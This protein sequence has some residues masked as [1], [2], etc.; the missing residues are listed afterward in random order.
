MLKIFKSQYAYSKAYIS[1]NI[2]F[3][4]Q[5]K[6]RLAVWNILFFSM[7]YWSFFVAQPA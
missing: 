6:E 1:A 7:Q 5:D 2:H 3:I 4:F